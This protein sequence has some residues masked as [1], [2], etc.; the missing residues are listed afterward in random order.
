[1]RLNALCISALKL[2]SLRESLRLTRRV[3]G[4]DDNGARC[5][6]H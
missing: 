5:Q 3:F 2:I 4:L 6:L 1:V